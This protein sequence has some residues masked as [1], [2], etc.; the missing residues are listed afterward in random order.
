[1]RLFPK[2]LL[3]ACIAVMIIAVAAV[4][5]EAA[6]KKKKRTAPPAPPPAEM[7]AEP[8][9]PSPYCREA[10]LCSTNC[11]GGSCAVMVCSLP[12]GQWIPAFFTPACIQG[13]CP[14]RC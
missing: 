11:Q 5:S 7:V 10:G 14:P 4:P 1:M 6:K 2:R 13:Q 12:A 8:P 9:V 3:A